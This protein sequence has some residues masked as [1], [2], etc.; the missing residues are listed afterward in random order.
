VLGRGPSPRGML[1]GFVDSLLQSFENHRAGLSND[2]DRREA[3]AFFLALY[4][5]EAPHLRDTVRQGELALPEAS[6]D[7]FFAEVDD[8]VRRVVV[9]AYARLAGPFTRR[10]R[11][12]FYL[13]PESLHGLERVGFGVLGMLLGLFVVWAPFIPL[14]SKEWVLVF[15]IAGLVFPNLRRFLAL[16][17]YESEINRLV[18]RA[19]DEIWRK[20]LA[21]VTAGAHLAT[22]PHYLA[23]DEDKDAPP[24]GLE[25]RLAEAEAGDTP[26][27]ASP[28]GK[29]RQGGH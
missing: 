8:Y 24:A 28:K 18:L 29:I 22:E 14:W 23:E 7:T 5:K 15:V 20:D 26:E 9:P 11:N 12:D 21:Y 16:R 1:N 10:E 25:D 17:R 27:S 3:E 6:R 19:D 2:I 4:E 13:T